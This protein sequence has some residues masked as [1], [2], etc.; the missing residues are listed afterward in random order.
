L[1]VGFLEPAAILVDRAERVHFLGTDMIAEQRTRA[2]P[3]DEDPLWSPER[4]SRGFAA[5]E[6]FEGQPD[7]RSDLYAWGAI[8]FFLLTGLRVEEGQAQTLEK[9]LRG[10]PPAHV[11][12]W[13]GQLGVE[14]K[15]L[16][17]AW[18]RSVLK[19]FEPLLSADRRRRPSSVAELRSWLSA[20][21]A[22]PVSAA[23][24]VRTETQTARIFVDLGKADAGNDLII[25]RGVNLEPLRP[26]QGQLIAE[27]VIRALVDDRNLAPDGAA[28]IYGVFVREHLVS[29]PS[30]SAPV[31]ARLIDP[32]PAQ[33]LALA[34]T[35][36]RYVGEDEQEPPLVGLLFQA[37]PGMQVVEALLSSSSPR[38]RSWAIRRLPAL[39]RESPQAAEPILERALGDPSPER[40]I[41]TIRC[42]LDSPAGRS[43]SFVRRLVQ[44]L[45]ITSTADY[46][47][48]IEDLKESKS[49][50]ALF[51]YLVRAPDA[52]VREVGRELLLSR[53]VEQF[54]DREPSPVELRRE[55]DDLFLPEHLEEKIL[56]CARLADFGIRP[57][58]VG[59][60]LSLWEA[61]RLVGCTECAA[62]VRA[63]DMETHL[64]RAHAVFSFRGVRR[65]FQESRAFLLG[66][67][68]GPSPDYAAWKG[69]EEVAQDRHGPKAPRRL[70][71]WLGRHLRGLPRAQRGQ[72][73]GSA[74]EA[75][76]AAGSGP[77]LVRCLVAPPRSPGQPSARRLLAL[78]IVARM[79]PSLARTLIDTVK[80]LLADKHVAR[81]VR[82]NAVAALLAATGKGGT[83]A[84]DLLSAYLGRSGK[85]RSIDKLH[86]LEQRVGH[87][88]VIDALCAELEDQVR[89]NC[90]R[91][92]TELTRAEMIHHVWD[93]HRLVLEGRRVRDPWRLMGDWIEDYRLEK[94]P[95]LLERCRDLAAKLDPEAGP[96]RL[97][98]LLLQHGLDDRL[99]LNTLLGQARR[100]G[101]GLCPHC[102]GLLPVTASDSPKAL[103]YEDEHLSGHGYR[104]EVSD[105]GMIPWLEIETPEGIAYRGREPGRVLTRNGA[106]VLLVGPMVLTGFL[107]TEWLTGSQMPALA[108]FAVAGG[109]ALFLGGLV[110]LFWPEP[111]SSLDRLIDHAW[112]LL[113]PSLLEKPFNT[114]AVD[115][116]SGLAVSSIA[117]GSPEMRA[118]P[119]QELRVA[120]ERE[121]HGH[122]DL[123]PTL[124]ALW[125]LTV[126]DLGRQEKDPV[127]V[128]AERVGDCFTGES[129]LRLADELL[130]GLDWKAAHAG[131]IPWWTKGSAKRL[132]V[133][134]F[135]KAFQAGLEVLDLE[136]LWRAFPALAST[137][138]LENEAYAAA[139][140]LLWALDERR[141]WERAGAAATVF[142][143][144]A[145]PRAGE[146]LLEKFPDLLWSVREVS[147]VVCRRGVWF[148]DVWISEQPGTLEI[149][150]RRSKEGG[151]ELILS[152]Y[153]F[154]FAE[155]P[156]I[157]V[158]QIEKLL[159]FYFHDFLPQLPPFPGR[160]SPDA[161]RRLRNKNATR[162][163]ECRRFAL[164]IRG[165]VGVSLEEDGMSSVST[166]ALLHEA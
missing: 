20:P 36:A 136:D 15:G 59:A 1:V 11:R 78:E 39:L 105:H 163:P 53:L 52:R 44:A 121:G 58:T 139:L 21:P 98:R 147:A 49:L 51:P 38:V 75:I 71:S 143:L 25:R 87:A 28:I 69:L 118:E 116:L 102:Y 91:C 104:L 4:C 34:E 70:A 150:P 82:Q 85:L 79:P 92:H 117:A 161:L 159:R 94:D 90:P 57:E 114:E 153:R 2:E 113:T 107:L 46:H 61:D 165:E 142:E 122:H 64:R 86:Q 9:S 124:A 146:K 100:E 33:F 63:A 47:G 65:T 127:A 7:Y 96:R 13:A 89:M 154:I 101:G 31:L 95:A 81:D 157:V 133:L 22:P 144:A 131:K 155:Q 158:A 119:L 138:E 109:L 50:S 41:E 162:C 164:P 126:D 40:R 43:E 26:D 130:R 132:R 5:A 99:A 3:G 18:P 29:G 148:R 84:R 106:L 76:S 56:T 80:P 166:T 62:R 60:C 27:G 135:R 6:C 45:G 14:E 8:A 145:D 17:E 66:A 111:R 120:V 16:L 88:P 110:Y 97:L 35:E 32:D 10:I 93:R 24:A 42:L 103:R 149:R 156:D 54:G 55:F 77:D 12:A 37:A 140:R 151:Y 23:L 48:V 72:A 74:A 68:C 137:L 129:P 30:Y 19:T 134:L 160:R 73:A 125:R 108:L 83:A 115:F 152:P 128:I 123:I 67:V 112:E 141:P